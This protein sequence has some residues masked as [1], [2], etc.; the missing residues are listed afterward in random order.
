MKAYDNRIYRDPRKE[1]F[2]DPEWEEAERADENPQYYRQITKC[3][4]II[5][6]YK[7]AVAKLVMQRTGIILT[8]WKGEDNADNSQI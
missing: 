7:P 8:P 5:R 2:Y 1:P 6:K 3:G 4:I